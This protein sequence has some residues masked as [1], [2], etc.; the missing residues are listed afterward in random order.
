MADQHYKS[1]QDRWNEEL[2]DLSPWTKRLVIQDLYGKGQTIVGE[3]EPDF[4][5]SKI[6]QLDLMLEQVSHEDRAAYLEACK[7]S[8]ELESSKSLRLKFLR[9]EKFDAGLAAHRLTQYF[10]FKRQWFGDEL[11]G[12]TITLADLNEF[13]QQTLRSGGMQILSQ[14]DVGGRNVLFYRK[15]DLE[16][17]SGQNVVSYIFENTVILPRLSD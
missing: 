6:K 17:K 12:K 1:E 4:V 14:K 5:G 9:A 11:L 13:D 10:D 8:P 2:D 3:E 16:F 7:R 15:P